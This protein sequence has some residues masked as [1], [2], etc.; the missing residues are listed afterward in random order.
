MAHSA[1]SGVFSSSSFTQMFSTTAMTT[2]AGVAAACVVAFASSGYALPSG[3]SVQEGTITINPPA[4][5]NLSIDQT[6]DRGVINWNTFNI[7]NGEGV[8]FNQPSSTSATLNRV[9]GDTDASTIRGNLSANGQVVIVNPNGVLF[10]PD[11]NVDVAGLIATSADI[12]NSDFMDGGQL[13]FSTA[14]SATAKVENKGNITAKEGGIV[15]LVAP[16]VR[17]AGVISAS[18]GS[19]MLAAGQTATLDFYGDGL[20]NFT[21]STVGGDSSGNNAIVQSDSGKIQANGGEVYITANAAAEVVDQVIN[22]N[23]VVEANAI[24]EGPGG[25]V[26]VGE[27]AP[28]ASAPNGKITIK[29]NGNVRARAYL[30]AEEVHV[31]ALNGNDVHVRDILAQTEEGQA[32]LTIIGDDITVD[33]ELKALVNASGPV[34]MD[35][36]DP[37][38]V[39]HIVGDV[40]EIINGADNVIEA[41]DDVLVEGKVHAVADR[42]GDIANRE[43]TNSNQVL[44]IIGGNSVTITDLLSSVL[45]NLA[46]QGGRGGVDLADVSTG[47]SLDGLVLNQNKGAF[48]PGTISVTSFDGGNIDT[49]VLSMT[50]TASPDGIPTYIHVHAANGGNVLVEAIDMYIN[51]IPDNGTAYTF[52]TSLSGESVEVARDIDIF[53]RDNQGR[54][55]ISDARLYVNA[56]NNVTFGGDV[57]VQAQSGIRWLEDTGTSNAYIEINAGGD[58]TGNRIEAEALG[59]DDATAKVCINTCIEERAFGDELRESVADDTTGGGGFV[60]LADVIATAASSVAEDWFPPAEDET[61]VAPA[62]YAYVGRGEATAEISIYGGHAVDTGNVLATA[63]S[64]YKSYAEIDIRAGSVGGSYSGAAELGAVPDSYAA[65]LGT[66]SL[67]GLAR[68]EA[69]VTP[70]DDE[71]LPPSEEVGIAGY[72]ETDAY[73]YLNAGTLIE[74]GNVEA[75]ANGGADASAAIEANA[76]DEDG[77]INLGNL[78]SDARTNYNYGYYVGDSSLSLD[79]Y[80]GI[81]DAVAEVRLSATDAIAIG[82]SEAYAQS[83]NDAIATTF[84]TTNSG[85]GTINAGNVTSHADVLLHIVD[86][87]DDDYEDEYQEKYETYA[88]SSLPSE[89][90]GHDYLSPYGSSNADVYMNAGGGITAQDVSALAHGGSDSTAEVTIYSFGEIGAGSNGDSIGG[91]VIT[92][93]DVLAEAINGV[94]EYVYATDT[95]NADASVYGSN[96]YANVY[97]LGGDV[98]ADDVA[99]YAYSTGSAYA[100]VDIF[101]SIGSFVDPESEESEA[102]TS[103]T[104]GTITVNDVTAF[105]DLGSSYGYGSTYARVNL[106]AQTSVVADDLTALAYDGMQA[107][108]IINAEAGENGE[109][110]SASVPPAAVSG[111][112]DS[113]GTPF[114]N[115]TVNVDSAFAEAIT[116]QGYVIPSDV[117]ISEVETNDTPRGGISNGAYASID[118]TAGDSVTVGDATA[119]SFDD[120]NAVSYVDVESNG[121]TRVGSLLAQANTEY[122]G[123]PYE[124]PYY[125]ERLLLN[126]SY[127]G[128]DGYGYINAEATVRITANG[129]ADDDG[130]NIIFTGNDPKAQANDTERQKR[131][132]DYE[133]SSNA[134]SQ[135]I[136]VNGGDTPTVP[137]GSSSGGSSGSGSGGSLPLPPSDPTQPGTP[138]QPG[139]PGQPETPGDQGG[140]PPSGPQFPAFG[141]DEL[142]EDYDNGFNRGLFSFFGNTLG[143]PYYYGNTNVNLS[144]LASG[145]SSGG[146]LTPGQL[147]NLAPAAG[148][149]T[150]EDL[151]QLSPAAGGNTG[152]GGGEGENS[153]G[154][155]Y[156]DDGFSPGFNAEVCEEEQEQASAF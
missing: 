1:H 101:A 131:T 28:A 9:T 149:A 19:V 4:G 129:T 123:D 98:I 47:Q 91:G 36:M 50:G 138:E 26:I 118:L 117:R 68:S 148:G 108:A 63:H 65:E 113:Y 45:A 137:G 5:A 147:G 17:N 34:L 152:T 127:E 33:G 77:A 56:D 146:G 125:D 40:T 21:T 139:T 52:Y 102:E 23:G 55:R 120:Y 27:E 13:N 85:A 83:D 32:L 84:I 144:L 121:T 42:D 106:D 111:F 25:L 43:M 96:A 35:A 38:G 18:K 31:E 48:N 93:Q 133:A 87:R 66:I 6:S 51:D 97:I 41:A 114:V 72:G 16:N 134:F 24:S 73:V 58:I 80:G 156:L 116:S 86:D 7:G 22:L 95:Q 20:I 142:L 124:Y 44:K 122:T 103:V 151:G 71:T 154:N 141:L 12:A 14:G 37:T 74:G 135:L 90:E 49:G 2:R 46:V 89:E 115:G 29:G 39:I 60:H 130:S 79:V 3:G 150:A 145:G 110:M 107:T 67:G 30:E 136:I 143:N 126:D 119:N 75:V 92:L 10:G 54:T 57:T 64:D 69:I 109:V 112:L 155:N 140:T 88:Y 78:L 105:A 76:L 94:S 11:S 132:S 59:G 153:C 15:A 82:D 61:D 81:G 128:G 99:A 100:N 8:Q 104:G 53:V 70:F 62:A